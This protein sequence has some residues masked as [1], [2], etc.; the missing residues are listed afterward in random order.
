MKTESYRN[1]FL[2]KWKWKWNCTVYTLHST[3]STLY[4]VQVARTDVKAWGYKIDGAVRRSKNRY[5]M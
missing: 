4:S 1:E 2:Y 3:L 5:F